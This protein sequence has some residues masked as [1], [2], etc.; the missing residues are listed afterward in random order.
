MVA[1]SQ[2]IGDTNP[3]GLGV[4]VWY[5]KSTCRKYVRAVRYKVYVRARYDIRCMYVLQYGCICTSVLQTSARSRNSKVSIAFS[6]ITLEMSPTSGMFK[7]CV[8]NLDASSGEIMVFSNTNNGACSW[9]ARV[10]LAV[11]NGWTSGVE[12]VRDDMEMLTGSASGDDG[13][14]RLSMLG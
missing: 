5:G 9:R 11:K 13:G 3:R 10:R 14:D 2:W 1:C 12:G 6:D 8:Q 7:A 4:A